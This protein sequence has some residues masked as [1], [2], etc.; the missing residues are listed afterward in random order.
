[1]CSA[2]IAIFK[3]HIRLEAG[4]HLYLIYTNVL[5]SH[6][7]VC[8]TREQSLWLYHLHRQAV[9]FSVQSIAGLVINYPP[10]I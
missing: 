6:L 1:M 2:T 8:G 5:T 9:I 7:G 3:I 4:C 10:T